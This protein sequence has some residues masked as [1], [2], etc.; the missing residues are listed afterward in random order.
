MT[1]TARSNNPGGQSGP[2]MS[3]C[4]CGR[5]WAKCENSNAGYGLRPSS[6]RVGVSTPC[7]T[8]STGVTSCGRRGSGSERTGA[9]PGW[10]GSPWPRWRSTAWSGC[11]AS[12]AMTSVRVGI[13]RRRPGGWT[14]RNQMVAGGRWGSR[15]SGT[16]WRRRPRRSCWN[17]FSRP[18]SCRCRTGFGRD[19]RRP[20]RWRRLRVGFIEGI[21]HVVEFDI[22]DFFGEIDHDRLLALVGRRV[23]DRRVLKLIRQWL[24]AGVMRTGRSSGRSRG[25][26]RAG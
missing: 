1:G 6:L 26:R 13:V 10:I 20:R 4:A 2:S 22:R 18:T 5:T 25:P 8:G 23:S 21:T 11:C 12:C 14:S 17:R 3:R 16:G 19:G 15:R 7:M 24:E 9:R